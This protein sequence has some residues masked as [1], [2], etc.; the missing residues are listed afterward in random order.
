MKE[1]GGIT[2]PEIVRRAAAKG[3]D[4]SPNTI[5]YILRGATKNPGIFTIEAIAVALEKAPEQLTAEFLGFR[6]DDPSFKS[7]Q[8]AML[9]SVYKS[10]APS[11]KPKADPH[12]E[13]LMLVFQHIKS[14]K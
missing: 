4:I 9:D 10:M 8:F 6:S 13:A 11:Q 14:Q 7:S 1:A 2:V 12:V 3:Y 5:N